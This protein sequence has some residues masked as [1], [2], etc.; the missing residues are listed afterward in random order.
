[1]TSAGYTERAG[2]RRVRGVITGILGLGLVVS[3]H[4]STAWAAELW[5]CE[6]GV[7]TNRP[8]SQRACQPFKGSRVC[9]SGLNRYYTPERNGLVAEE[10]SCEPLAPEASPFVNAVDL[11]ADMSKPKNWERRL[12][13]TLAAETSRENLKSDLDQE[14]EEIAEIL[15]LIPGGS[16]VLNILKNQD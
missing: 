1:M 15:P 6:G 12:E 16:T 11:K 2:D 4:A 10:A 8:A 13:S 7:F 5:R 9:G 3:L 14:L